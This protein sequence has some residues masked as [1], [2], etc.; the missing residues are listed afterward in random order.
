MITCQVGKKKIDTFSYEPKQLREWS[1]KGLLRCPV[2]GSKMIY[3]H[4]EFKIPHF[5]HEKNCDC[6]DI[7]S[8]GV[9]E[10][11]IKGIELL[12]NWLQKQEGIT[13]IELEKWIPE[14]KQRP[15]IYFEY[16]NKPYVIEFQCSPIATKF[17]E[18]RELYRLNEINDI[19]ILGCDKY[20]IGKFLSKQVDYENQQW[21]FIE[22]YHSKTIER[23]IYTTFNNLY[24]IDFCRGTGMKISNHDLIDI[25]YKTKHK[26]HCCFSV[27]SDTNIKTFLLT[28]ECLSLEFQTLKSQRQK[29][30]N[31]L[32]KKCNEIL[33]YLN[34]ISPSNVWYFVKEKYNYVELIK[35]TTPYGWSDEKYY[36]TDCISNIECLKEIIQKVEIEKY[37]AFLKKQIKANELYKQVRQ[38]VTKIKNKKINIDLNIE[39]YKK[40]GVGIIIDFAHKEDVQVV[41]CT[42]SINEKLK[43]ILNKLT[44]ILCNIQ[45]LGNARKNI[46]E[47]IINQMLNINPIR[48]KKMN[49]I[50]KYKII[51]N[52]EEI[53][54]FNCYLPTGKKH[55]YN[56]S[57]VYVYKNYIKHNNKKQNYKNSK[58]L[59][60]QMIDI[61]SN[62]IRRFRYE[63]I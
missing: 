38:I 10:E 28:D 44:F 55:N 2:C 13:N 58:D 51:N 33:D 43:K 31:I 62:D 21:F 60:Q 11:H 49:I 63:C 47:E 57:T 6:P 16:E 34:Y 56:I 4:G 18:R 3:N 39:E 61:I 27:L 46:L 42:A 15:D 8:E 24:Y 40:H 23:E 48:N 29:N 54:I 50:V 32:M 12:H 25:G 30:K 22:E 37:N 19:W 7:Y 52:N 59:K 17:L 20:N 14:T 45:P 26:A 53:A 5:K 41:N 1:N 36:H 9:T 35:K